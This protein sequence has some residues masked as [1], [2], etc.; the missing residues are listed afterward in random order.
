VATHTER[1]F[2]GVALATVASMFAAT[3]L[4]AVPVHI[5]KTDL[6]PGIRA[7][8]LSPTQFAVLVPHA[9]ST[10]SGGSWSTAEARAAWRYAVEVPT[11]V[12]MSFHATQSRLP[13]SAVLVVRGAKTT[14]SYRARDLHRGELWSRIQPGEALEFTLTVAAAE[15]SKVALNIVSLQAGYRSLGPGVKDHPYY[16]QLKAQLDAATGNAACVTNYECEVTTSNTPPGAATV[17]LIIGNEWNC[18]GVLI[19]DVPRDNTPYVLTARHCENGQLGGGNPAAASSVTVYWEATTPCG[20]A[21]GSLYDPGIPTQTGAQTVV[22]QQDAWLIELDINPVVSDAQ[23]AGFD[24]SGGAVQGGYSIHHAEGYNKQ[25]TAWFDQAYVLQDS[26]V[27]GTTYVSNFLET[28]NQIGNVAPGASGGGLFDQNNHLVGSLTLGRTTS[29]PSGYGACPVVPLSAPNGTNGVADFTSLAAVWNSTADTTSTTGSKTLKSILDSANT[30]VLVVSSMAVAPISF[31]A[32][33]TVLSTGQTAQLSWSV[34]NATGCTA[35]G[36]VPGDGWSGTLPATGTQS[37]SETA[38]LNAT[39]KLT[40]RLTTGG[41]VSSSIVIVWDGE[42]PTVSVYLPRSGVWTT[43]PAVVTW[44]SNVSPCSV[45]GGS[46]SLTGQASS[47]SVTTTQSSPGDVTYQVACGAGPAAASGSATESYVTPSLLLVANGTDRRLGQNFELGW[48]TFADT[49]TPSGG[50][51]DDGWANNSFGWTTADFYPRVTTPG[52]YTYTLICSSGPL[53]V[54][55]SITVTF[56]DNAP[57]VTATVSPSTTTYSGSPADYVKVNWTTNLSGCGVNS[58]PNL[59]AVV[60]TPPLAPDLIN[61]FVDGPEVIAPQ[62]SGTYTLS[63]TCV[64]PGVANVTSTPMIVTVQP[65]P[66]PTATI[67]INPSTVVPLG[68]NFT[69]AWS[70]TNAASCAESGSGVGLPGEAWGIN[71]APTG[72]FTDNLSESNQFTLIISCIS[73]DPNQAATAT[74][75]VSL[76][77]GITALTLTANP[78]SVDDGGSFTLTWS[79]KGA[80]G[81]ENCAASGGGADGSHWSGALSTSGSLKEVATTPGTFTY[82]IACAEGGVQYS[83]DATVTVAAG[84]GGGGS[85]GSG[86][87]GSGHGGGGAIGLLELALLAGTR[88]LC[89]RGCSPWPPSPR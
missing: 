46:L 61:F 23:F 9:V 28:V 59:G 29:D 65:S 50:A 5:V 67:S 17:G 86:G 19:N 26:G 1:R 6:K 57:Y 41:S 40:C 2:C 89:R 87:S 27:L 51:P 64:G 4:A 24:A 69:V 13:E 56:E 63:V 72:S 15:R 75:Q 31:T 81:A 60:Q 35:A 16:H 62:A 8:V 78:S 88:G 73:I 82:T 79:S 30:G 54:Q 58:T 70:S 22:E 43:R 10:S 85:G 11:A 20:T 74:A 44:T 3:A 34:P 21:L 52:T 25:F 55:Q 14:V 66:P 45:S 18:T 47:G 42:V 76:T 77:V 32:N 80:T 12:S 84:A 48:Y 83:A 36:G 7:G 71:N 39:Y 37:V 38:G 68:Q 53:S 49:C 33:P